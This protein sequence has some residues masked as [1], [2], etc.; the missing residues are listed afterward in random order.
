MIILRASIMA[1]GSFPLP[2][3]MSN[4]INGW[5]LE[6]KSP[7]KTCCVLFLLGT[8]RLHPT[9]G[10]SSGWDTTVRRGVDWNI[11]G[12][13]KFASSIERCNPGNHLPHD[14]QVHVLSAL[15]CFDAFQI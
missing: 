5:I 15:V 7:L 13:S 12:A 1:S 10:T 4:C 9:I 14:Q 11:R 6:P 2:M 8:G 3:V